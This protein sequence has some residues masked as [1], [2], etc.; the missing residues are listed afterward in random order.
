MRSRLG[1]EQ[2]H[3][4]Q[5]PM[6]TKHLRGPMLDTL[7]VALTLSFYINDLGLRC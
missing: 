3:F 2:A 4:D 1:H 7:G 5:N 6:V